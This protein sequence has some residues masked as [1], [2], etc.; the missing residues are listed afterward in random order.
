MGAAASKQ[1]EVTVEFKRPE[2]AG[3]VSVSITPNM[4]RS[5]RGIEP[6]AASATPKS[7]GKQSLDDVVHNRVQRELELQ[8]FKKLNTEK[9]TADLLLREADDLIKRQRITPQPEIKQDVVAK[10]QALASC[11]KS[12][13]GRSLDCWREVEDLKAAL[14]K[15]QKEF[16]V[17]ASA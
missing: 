16:F 1:P 8:K 10:E 14:S 13:T 7:K 5:L 12:N 9:M 6:Q 17:N 11:Y 3:P 15:A 2:G 4:L